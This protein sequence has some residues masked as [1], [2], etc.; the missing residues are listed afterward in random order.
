MRSFYVF[1][2]TGFGSGYSPI[3]PGT[4]GSIVGCIMFYF[5]HAFFPDFFPG[6]GMN[7]VYFIVLTL[8]FL[9]IGV[10]ASHALEP[11]WGED[12]QKI[13][14]DEIVG[15][16]VTLLFIPYSDLNLLL[17]L[18]LFRVFDIWK[19]LG[20]RKFEK[21]KNGWGVMM[22]DVVA[23]VYANICLQVYIWLT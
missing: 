3:A 16:W 2:S 6:F 9:I 5:F 7:S 15:V 1:M 17:A 18:V 12:P 11:E 8:V 21:M 10:K 4:A 20:I 14:I 23:G 22:D 19:P 13:V